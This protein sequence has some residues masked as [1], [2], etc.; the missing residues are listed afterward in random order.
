VFLSRIF[1]SEPRQTSGSLQTNQ[2]QL[3]S[4]ARVGAVFPAI[5]G[6]RLTTATPKSR[7]LQHSAHQPTSPK[8]PRHRPAS[9]N[10]FQ[11]SQNRTPITP[12]LTRAEI[13]PPPEPQPHFKH[14]R[15]Q[16]STVQPILSSRPY[17]SVIVCLT[18]SGRNQHTFSARSPGRESEFGE[19]PMQ[20]PC[21]CTAL[22]LR[23]WRAGV[24]A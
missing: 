8:L 6:F 10:R 13:N 19:R 22:L 18:I 14:L 11:T 15:Y 2:R 17:L 7:H 3:L 16:S 20:R 24:L 9:I 12:R 4:P 23:V 21:V 5:L 1:V